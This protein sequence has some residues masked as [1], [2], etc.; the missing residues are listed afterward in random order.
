MASTDVSDAR[1]TSPD[2]RKAPNI[3]LNN[4]YNSCNNNNININNNNKPQIII[5]ISLAR[6]PWPKRLLRSLHWLPIRAR[7][8]YNI[9]TLC[10]RSRHSSAPT[11]SLCS[12][13]AGLMTVPRINL[14]KNEKRAFSYIGPLILLCTF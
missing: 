11:R 1:L 13:D 8:K 7:I 10:Y 4:H 5:K 6:D 12:A 9:P 14:N 2:T 3:G